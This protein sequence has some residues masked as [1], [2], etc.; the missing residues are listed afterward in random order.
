[1]HH[2]INSFSS[3]LLP[4]APPVHRHRSWSTPCD[5]LPTPDQKKRRDDAVLALRDPAISRLP[6]NRNAV[7]DSNQPAMSYLVTLLIS[8]PW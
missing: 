1:M 5:T 8:S 4:R 7:M 2:M 3:S 6:I